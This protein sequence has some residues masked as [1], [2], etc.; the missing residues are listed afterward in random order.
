MVRVQSIPRELICGSKGAI[1]PSLSPSL[2]CLS[3]FQKQGEIKETEELVG[4]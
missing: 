4:R 2:L 3:F 1:P